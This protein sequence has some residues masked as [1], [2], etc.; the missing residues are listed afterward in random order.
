[1]IQINSELPNCMLD[2]NNQLNEYDFVLFHLRS[3][4]N[5]SCSYY[6]LCNHRGLSILFMFILIPS[7]ALQ[8]SR[9]TIPI[10]QMKT[11]AKPR[12]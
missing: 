5:S 8:D 2:L 6:L 7:V 4:N 12:G 11:E 9:M 1:M 3:R 10:F